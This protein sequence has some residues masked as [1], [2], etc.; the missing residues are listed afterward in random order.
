MATAFVKSDDT[1]IVEQKLR[2]CAIGEIV[3]Y[4]ALSA[5]ISRDIRSE[6]YSSLTSARRCCERDGIVFDV[7]INEGLRRLS[8]E[9]IVSTADAAM[10]KQRRI[11]QRY[12]KRLE[13][14]DIG[15]L[16]TEAKRELVAR[17]AQLSAVELFASKKANRKLLT[18]ADT[19]KPERIAIAAALKLFGGVSDKE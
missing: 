10:L 17:S 7:V 4:Q 2:D 16:S 9:E 12:R 18:L 1:L 6:A 13:Q 11:S 14:V 15:K 5:A 19:E 8:D 3:T